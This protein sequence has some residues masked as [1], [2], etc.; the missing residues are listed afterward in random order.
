MQ[1]D[2]LHPYYL[3]AMGVT[4]WKYC[5]FD[6]VQKAHR[7]RLLDEHGALVALLIAQSGGASKDH[8]LKEK[9]LL[10]AICRAMAPKWE[11]TDASFECLQ[12]DAANQ[13]G[14]SWIL[15]G[16]G[17]A[18]YVLSSE[19]PLSELRASNQRYHGGVAIATYS[20]VHLLDNPASKRE[21]WKD[22]QQVVGM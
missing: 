14:V 3:Q 1:S 20:A 9:N 15:M 4:Q 17:V 13:Q 22:L 5:P 21:A 2:S 12:E 7:Y 11:A 18:Q 16:E 8:A 19:L 6:P 10:E